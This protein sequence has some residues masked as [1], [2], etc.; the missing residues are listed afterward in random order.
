MM[1]NVEWQKALQEILTDSF[2]QSSEKIER[3]LKIF[4]NEWNIF[5]SVLVTSNGLVIATGN[6]RDYQGEPSAIGASGLDLFEVSVEI[7]EEI[8]QTLI[9]MSRDENSLRLSK[10]VGQV[11]GK[12]LTFQNFVLT[13]MF[14]TAEDGVVYN[15]LQPFNLILAPIEGI[16]FLMLVID[17]NMEKNKQEQIQK[18]LPHLVK[19]LQKCLEI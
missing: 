5:Y 11:R 9:N 17:G 3:L 10:M 4:E 18:T 6:Q 8:L 12:N 7:I 13:P 19:T 2:L 15:V 1:W 14:G 16:G